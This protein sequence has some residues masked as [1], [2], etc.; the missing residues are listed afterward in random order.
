MKSVL[1]QVIIPTSIA[2]I[3]MLMDTII[4]DMNLFHT[5]KWG[6][7]IFFFVQSLLSTLVTDFG[8]KTEEVTFQKFYMLS[9]TIRLFLSIILIFIFIFLKAEN[10]IFLVTNFFALY[11]FYMLFEIYFLLVNLRTNSK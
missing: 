8:M 1:T 5:Y 11:F 10:L 7:L 6:L 3:F 9:I 4:P 2:G